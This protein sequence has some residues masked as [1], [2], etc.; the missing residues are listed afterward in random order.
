M[1]GQVVLHPVANLVHHKAAVRHLGCH[2]AMRTEK[3]T[4]AAGAANHASGA[5]KGLALNKPLNLGVD[6]TWDDIH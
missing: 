4:A 1:P 6:L 2:L 5:G 3:F